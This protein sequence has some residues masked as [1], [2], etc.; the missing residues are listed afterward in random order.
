[1]VAVDARHLSQEL[2]N[3]KLDDE[4]V[5]YV[6]SFQGRGETCRSAATDSVNNVVLTL[7]QT[8]AHEIGHLVGFYHTQL[9]DIM[10]RSATLGFQRELN[11]ERGQI[12]IEVQRNGQIITEALTTVIQEPALY[13]LTNFDSSPLP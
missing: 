3:Q 10:N 2:G 4:A 1:M 12:E 6:G 7:A 11:F 9:I 8:A 13:F 5:V